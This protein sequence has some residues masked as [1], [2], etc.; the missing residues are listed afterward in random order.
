MTRRTRLTPLARE[1][2]AGAVLGVAI[3]AV[4]LIGFAR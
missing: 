4:A 2:L 3:F 1:L